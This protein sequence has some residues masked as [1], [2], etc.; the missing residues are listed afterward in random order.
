[1]KIQTNRLVVADTGWAESIPDWIKEEIKSERILYGMA[2]IMN[3]TETV[4]DAEVAAYLFTANL[5]GPV[6]HE[7]GQIYIY[8]TGKL[9]QKS[10]TL[11]DNELPDFIQKK[12]K[13]GLDE[14]EKYELQ[15]LKHDLY[16]K[17]GGE[18][19]SPILNILRGLSKK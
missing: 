16:R 14:D 3:K 19:N 5:K 13:E 9:M 18:I 15:R 1:M 6:S 2:D 11:S 4:G 7:F 17:R 10:K 8:L 12:V